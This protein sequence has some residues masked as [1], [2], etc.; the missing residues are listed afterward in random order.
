MVSTMLDGVYH[1]TVWPLWLPWPQPD[2]ESICGEHSPAIQCH[3]GLAPLGPHRTPLGL[4]LHYYRLSMCCGLWVWDLSQKAA[5]VDLLRISCDR[6][7]PTA[8]EEKAQGGVVLYR[9]VEEAG[10]VARG[11]DWIECRI[12]TSMKAFIMAILIGYTDPGAGV[13]YSRPFEESPRGVYATEQE[14]LT[15]AREKAVS[16]GE[17]ARRHPDLSIVHIR[18]DCVA[19]LDTAGT[20]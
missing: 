2:L 8:Q 17:S 20:V 4:S 7:L 9:V 19:T 14:C 15:A 1:L 16:L 5:R 13:F 10:D 12:T 11:P 3:P 6:L 18:I